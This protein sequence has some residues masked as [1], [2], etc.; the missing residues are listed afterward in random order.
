MPLL[1][2]GVFVASGPRPGQ[3][4]PVRANPRA[5]R[6][7]PAV[8]ATAPGARFS[9]A[10]RERLLLERGIGPTTVERLERAGFASLEA[11]RRAGVQ[12]VVATVV[13]AVETPGWR[14]RLR[15]LERVVQATQAR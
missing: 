2:T 14:N 6:A 12:Q 8:A 3:R 11:L 10:E 15:A 9:P 4:L 13:S 1:T 7:L 5:A